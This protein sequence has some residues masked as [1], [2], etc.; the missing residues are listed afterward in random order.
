MSSRSSFS[1]TQRLAKINRRQI[2]AG[3][4]ISEFDQEYTVPALALKSYHLRG[5]GWC[6]DWFQYLRNNHPVLGICCHHRLHPIKTGMRLVVF[7]GSIV[8]GLLVTNV[9]WMYYYYNSDETVFST[10]GVTNATAFVTGLYIKPVD[11]TQGMLVNWTVGGCSHAIFD[12]AIWHLTA[13]FCCLPGQFLGCLDRYRKYGTY[14]VI[15]AV[16]V[17]AACATCVVVLR[18]FVDATHVKDLAELANYTASSGDDTTLLDEMISDVMHAERFRFLISYAVELGLA[19]FLYNPL[20]AFI[21]FSGVLGCCGKLPVLG[22]R[23]YEIGREERKDAAKAN[24]DDTQ[25]SPA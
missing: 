5:N 3:G 8:F 20:I 12:N 13:C 17:L 15:L 16:V 2:S 23:P 24:S 7:L 9:I 10:I 25:S 22:G 1:S 19:L 4:G 18:A 6:A 21:M 11:I 14:F